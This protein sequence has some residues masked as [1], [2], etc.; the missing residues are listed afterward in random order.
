MFS[1]LP[2]VAIVLILCCT[3]L[4]D[5][6][7]HEVGVFALSSLFLVLGIGL[8]NLGADVAMSPMGEQIGSGLTKSR[9]LSVL[10]FRVFLLRDA[11]CRVDV[12]PFRRVQHLTIFYLERGRLTRGISCERVYTL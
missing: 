7:S 11:F 10:L 4:K 3:P 9:K 5:L 2:V 8:F 1:V 6:T 12:T